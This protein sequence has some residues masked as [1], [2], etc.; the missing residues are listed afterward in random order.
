MDVIQE[1]HK[2][3]SERKALYKSYGYGID[4]ERV[5]IVDKAQP[6]HGDILEAGT[7][8][9][10]FTLALAKQGYRFTTF[11]ISEEEQR[12]AKFNLKYFGLEKQVNFK[13]ENAEYLNFKNAGFDIIFSANMLHHLVNPYKVID[14]FIR[15]LSFEGK[16]VLSDFTREGFE[17]VDKIHAIEGRVHEVNKTTLCDIENYLLNKEF[18]IQKSRSRFQEVLIAYHKI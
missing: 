14:E 7:G 10:H 18:R 15:V 6:L 8:K 3:Y 17:I 9:G 1:N 12:L 5:F 11:D 4:E 2:R 13:I 16:I